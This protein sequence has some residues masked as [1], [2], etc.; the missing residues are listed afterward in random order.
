MLARDAAMVIDV[1]VADPS[2]MG[3]YL[4]GFGCVMEA[5]Y[6]ALCRHARVSREGVVCCVS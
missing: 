2:K 5:E 4:L 3:L 1:K 6:A